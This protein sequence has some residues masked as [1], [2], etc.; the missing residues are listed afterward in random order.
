MTI[1]R[2]DDPGTPPWPAV[3]ESAPMLV[4]YKHSPICM[5]SSVA[6]SEIRALHQSLPSLPIYLVDVI[7]DRGLA[8]RIAGDLQVRHESPQ[9]LVI[10]DGRV[11]WHTSH[12][13]IKAG[14]L[15]AQIE[16]LR[17]THDA[18]TLGASST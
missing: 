6:H 1:L 10:R 8:H 4:L 14:A 13:A 9:V 3:L 12:F 11:A 16:R 18:A 17:T 15:L 2:L 5:T 7:R